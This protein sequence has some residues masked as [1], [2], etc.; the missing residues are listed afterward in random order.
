MEIPPSC[1]YRYGPIS[2]SNV[3]RTSSKAGGVGICLNEDL[4]HAR[5][6]Y[7]DR[8]IGWRIV[9]G[10][11]QV[12]YCVQVVPGQLIPMECDNGRH[13]HET[14]GR[15]NLECLVVDYDYRHIH[16]YDEVGCM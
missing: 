1:D 10:M 7:F 8:R 6:V 16:G 5:F 15:A 11:P 14:P 2:Q 12:G 3:I 13:H 9:D 4:C